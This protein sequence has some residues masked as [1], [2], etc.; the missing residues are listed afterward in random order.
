MEYLLRQCPVKGH[1]A[2]V[3]E[4]VKAESL[5]RIHALAIMNFFARRQTYATM[6]DAMP[7]INAHANHVESVSAARLEGRIVI[8]T[9]VRMAMALDRML[10]ENSADESRIAVQDMLR[11]A[12]TPSEGEIILL[13]KSGRNTCDR[14][15]VDLTPVLTDVQD[16]PSNCESKSE[17]VRAMPDVSHVDG[18]HTGVAKEIAAAT[19][20]RR[21]TRANPSPAYVSM[22]ARRATLRGD[23][24]EIINHIHDD[25]RSVS[26]SKTKSAAETENMPE[27]SLDA[28]QSDSAEC[29]H[30]AFPAKPG[31]S[32]RMLID[33]GA[34]CVAFR[35]EYRQ[36][37]TSLRNCRTS[38][39]T[40][41]GSNL[42]SSQQR[43]C[44]EVVMNGSGS[45]DTG[46]RLVI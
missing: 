25:D 44:V 26:A 41:D 36:K 34:N 46:L 32:T 11:M 16:I 20:E 17:P 10:P 21:S 23:A 12:A 9:M 35:D 29:E 43:G 28:T 22:M 31:G 38:M 37:A 42:R 15:A 33:S 24:E 6:D 30:A 19:R 8:P 2:W 45:K 13:H 3:Y 1:A 5:A 18:H 7:L 27:S 14:F 4:R 40:C 39:E